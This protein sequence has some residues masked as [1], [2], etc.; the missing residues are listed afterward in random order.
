MTD[1]FSNA[2]RADNGEET[3]RGNRDSDAGQP[4]YGMDAL[5]SMS[6]PPPPKVVQ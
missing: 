1:R 2:G 3:D 5:K 6:G 4:E